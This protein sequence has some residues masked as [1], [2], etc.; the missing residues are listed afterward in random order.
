M[1]FKEY[2]LSELAKGNKG[3]YGIGASAVD[4]DKELYT[5]LRITDINE[6]GTLNYA[7]LK[8]VNDENADKYILE[9]GDIVFARTGNSTG[10]SYYYDGEISN[11]VY[12]GFLIKFSLD[13]KKVNPK[14]VK[15]YTI[16]TE[17]KNWV[18]EIQTG[19]TRGNI[20]EKMYGNMRMKLP[21]RDYQD[22]MVT[23]LE[24][25]D[26]KIRLNNQINDNLYKV[27]NMIFQEYFCNKQDD[28]NFEKVQIKDF[29]SIR[30]GLAY[31]ASLLSDNVDDNILVSMGN[32]ELNTIFNFNNLKHYSENVENRYVGKIGDLFICTRDVTQKRNQLGC[33]GI[34][35]KI[36]KGKNVIIGT[37]LYIVDIL[38]NKKNI[39]YFLF[40]LM[41]SNEYGERIVGSAKGTAVLM[42][43]KDDILKFEFCYPKEE[44]IIDDFNN[45]VTPIFEKIESVI[46]END[47]LSNLRDTLLPKLMN[48]EI[49]LD[50]IKI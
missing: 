2:T 5:Y 34:I 29:I 11:L 18:K 9:K 44:K 32:V 38:N 43:A 35:P 10:K 12:A 49:D 36:F 20:N 1:E 21:P 4:Y 14:F 37:N 23:I 7:N 8:S 50:K 28:E 3:S 42:I 41:N 25:V 30:G 17:Y 15:Y 24:N 19:S 31:K 45:K 47:R 6:D 40:L 33:P 22:K 27:L 26:K 48:G 46:V 13:D 16:T 39:K